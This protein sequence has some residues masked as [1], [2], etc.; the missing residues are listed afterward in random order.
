[1]R[2]LHAE[3]VVQC[4]GHG[5][6]CGHAAGLA[7]ALGAPGAEA[8]F[9]FQVDDVDIA[10]RIEARHDMVGVKRDNVRFAVGEADP[11]EER[12][13]DAHRH[14]ADDLA[15]DRLGVERF[16]HVLAGDISKDSDCSSLWVDGEIAAVCREHVIDRAHLISSPVVEERPER[17]GR[18][19]DGLQRSACPARKLH[20]ADPPRRRAG[21]VDPVVRKHQPFA[22]SLQRVGGEPR[23]GGTELFRGIERSTPGHGQPPAGGAAREVGVHRF[24]EQPALQPDEKR[25]VERD[26]HGRHAQETLK[27]S[28]VLHPG[29]DS[30]RGG[31]RGNGERLDHSEEPALQ[32]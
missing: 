6:R 28:T 17:Q 13:A 21:V 12:L 7:D 1:M 23:G 4:V 32:D 15:A 5:N 14:A 19:A 30:D 2:Q 18:P 20:P 10:G 26:R 16:P 24:R 9:R 29:G 27:D 25:V 22:G 8:G 3:G 11:L 31:D